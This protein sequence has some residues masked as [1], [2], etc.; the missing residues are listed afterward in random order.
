MEENWAEEPNNGECL[1]W[2]T[3]YC[4]TWHNPNSETDDTCLDYRIMIPEGKEY[5][6]VFISSSSD[7]DDDWSNQ[8]NCDDYFDLP[9][10]EEDFVVHVTDYVTETCDGVTNGTG[11]TEHVTDSTGKKKDVLEADRESATGTDPDPGRKPSIEV[12][13]TDSVRAAANYQ[14][15]VGKQDRETSP[16]SCAAQSIVQSEHGGGDEVINPDMETAKR[17]DDI[18]PRHQSQVKIE[19][20]NTAD[21]CVTGRECATHAPP[22]EMDVSNTENRRPDLQF[23]TPDLNNEELST[24]EKYFTVAL[25]SGRCFNSKRQP[26]IAVKKMPGL[27]SDGADADVDS[28]TESIDARDPYPSDVETSSVSDVFSDNE[29]NSDSSSD[30]ATYVA[31]AATGRPL[32]SHSSYSLHTIMEESCEESDRGSGST[33]PTN[34][35]PPSELEKYFSLTIASALDQK[36]ASLAIS[37]D[38]LSIIS[39]SFSEN[40]GSIY[41]EMSEKANDVDPA[42]LAASRLEKYFTFGLLGNGKFCYPDD[43]EFTDESAGIGSEVDDCSLASKRNS[44]CSL[45]PSFDDNITEIVDEL[46]E[47]TEIAENAFVQ[48][49]NYDT[50]KRKKVKEKDEEDVSDKFCDDDGFSTVKRKKKDNE[51]ADLTVESV[52][53]DNYDKDITSLNFKNKDNFNEV[54]DEFLNCNS[55]NDYIGLESIC[56]LFEEIIL[57]KDDTEVETFKDTDKNKE[58]LTIIENDLNKNNVDMSEVTKPVD[59]DETDKVDTPVSEGY[60]DDEAKYIMNKLVAHFADA[61]VNNTNSGEFPGWELFESQIAQLMQTVSPASLSI[62]D[63]SGSSCSSST[64]GS[65]NSDYGSDTLESADCTTTDDD[66]QE[67]NGRNS[68]LMVNVH[69]LQRRGSEGSGSGESTDSTISEDTVYICKQLM[70]SLKKMVE[71]T[72]N[73]RT[74]NEGDSFSQARVYITEQIVALMHTVSASRNGSPIRER[75]QNISESLTEKNDV[76]VLKEIDNSNELS[77]SI[78]ELSNCS[79]DEEADIMF[80]SNIDDYKEKSLQDEKLEVPKLDSDLLTVDEGIS[81]DNAEDSQTEKHLSQKEYS[82]NDAYK[83]TNNDNIV[84]SKQKSITVAHVHSISKQN[85]SLEKIDICVTE[86]TEIISDNSQNVYLCAKEENSKL[87]TENIDEENKDECN[88]QRTLSDRKKASSENNLLL[89]DYKAKKK[90]GKVSATKSTGNISDLEVA[91][92]SKTACRDTGYYSLKSSDDSFLSLDE[93]VTSRASSASLSH[94]KSP[95]STETILEDDENIC[96]KQPQV[97]TV[98]NSKTT[99]LSSGNIPE[100]IISA[101][102]IKSSTL[103]SSVR[104]TVTPTHPP[105]SST[106]R[107]RPFVSSFFSTSGVL[108]KLAALRDENSPSYRISPR[109]RLGGRSRTPS[110]NDDSRYGMGSMPQLCFQEYAESMSGSDRASSLLLEEESDPSFIYPSCSQISL[111]SFGS[112]SESM[113]SVYSAAGGG[114]YGTVTVTG[115]VLFGLLYNKKNGTL[116]IYIKECRNLAPV[117]IKRNRSDP[118]VKVYLLPDR[119]KSGKRKTKVKKHTINPTFDEVLRFP[120][121]INELEQRTLWL[122]VWHSDMFGRNDF[123]GEILLALG[124]KLLENSGLKWYPL[125]ERLD[126]LESPFTF[127]GDLFLALKYVPA[128]LNIKKYKYPGLFAKGSLHVLMKEARNLMATRSNGTSDPFC[129][130]YL[131]PDKSKASKQ[132]TPVVKKTSNPKWYH[133]FVYEDVTLDDLKERCL[134]LTLWDYDKITSNDFLGG[135]RLSLGAGKSCGREVDWMDSRFEEVSLWHAMLE[136]PNMWVEGCLLLR[137]TM[138]PRR[139]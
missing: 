2:D 122:S 10:L 91:T 64:I 50:V 14:L 54:T 123:L 106:S 130:S 77:P 3:S 137:P 124:Q 5:K 56:Y 127:K 100:T 96:A 125:Q 79:S 133:T 87:Q 82:I 80:V 59:L 1:T 8:A 136:R 93:S 48:D 51:N 55:D 4:S 92:G 104:N 9:E 78:S 97:M 139:V 83:D 74:K 52:N 134:E 90:E 118:Y 70:Q 86:K 25:E 119:T 20:D 103:P 16:S 46:I 65:N 6:I 69:P 132:K 36:R 117:D 71:A 98:I 101:T 131:L 61:N 58:N 62:G 23:L 32:Y 115:E 66:D 72:H 29:D 109:G 38:D 12:Q 47:A 24:L 63:P 68:A 102:S 67:Q 126:T 7:T 26:S 17:C 114:R 44:I 15:W 88:I 135:V 75:K 33:T 27:V 94:Q 60:L 39:D 107:F 40:S 138:Q 99:S 81:V 120:V 18:L 85:S 111:S 31:P 49:N 84:H 121:T 42:V 43:A 89:A 95:A 13:Q 53:D 128:D 57:I 21:D 110:G 129:K 41:S 113:S 105:P 19:E 108:R 76:K 11:P 28:V 35:M 45:D 30:E 116:E 34:R 112:R 37:E 73:D 22:N